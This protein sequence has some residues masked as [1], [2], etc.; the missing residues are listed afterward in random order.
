MREVGFDGRH[1]T[2]LLAPVLFDQPGGNLFFEDFG[3]PIGNRFEFLLLDAGMDGP[4]SVAAAP[5]LAVVAGQGLAQEQLHAPLFGQ[6]NHHAHGIIPGQRLRREQVRF[7]VRRVA[8][9]NHPALGGAS[10][11][12]YLEA[13]AFR[14]GDAGCVGDGDKRRTPPLAHVPHPIHRID[15]VDP[16]QGQAPHF[17][18]PQ[19][20]AAL[21]LVL[22]NDEFGRVRQDLAVDLVVED[23]RVAPELLRHANAAV[24]LDAIMTRVNPCGGAN[25]VLGQAVRAFPAQ[26]PQQFNDADSVG[27]SVREVK[28]HAPE[29]VLVAEPVRLEAL[30]R[31]GYQRGLGFGGLGWSV[32]LAPDVWHHLEPHHFDGGAQFGQGLAEGGPRVHHLLRQLGLLPQIARERG[33][34]NHGDLLGFEQF[35]QGQV[36]IA[37]GVAGDG[38]S[39]EVAVRRGGKRE[40]PGGHVVLRGASQ[41]R[42]VGGYFQ[43]EHGGEG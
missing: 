32:T 11:G 6:V 9:I 7:Q 5:L 23:E 29:P 34:E 2:R 37:Q 14:L 22:G 39:G 40:F 3:N 20:T 4:Q 15:D 12:R 30:E 13:L 43:A 33:P 25:H 18:C 41:E 8:R 28:H 36:P 26:I 31:P 21:A 42:E 19:R 35:G 38:P 17:S 10:L 27:D 16:T 24:A 1:F